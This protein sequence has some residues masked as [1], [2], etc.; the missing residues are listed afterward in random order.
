MR[1]AIDELLD[2]SLRDVVDI[3][4]IV[5]GGHLRV[6]HDLQQHIAEFVAHRVVIVG[7][8]RLE[9]LV[10][11]LEQVPGQALMGLFGVPGTSAGPAQPRHDPHEVEQ[12]FPLL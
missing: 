10:G 5:V 7:I 6:E 8:D 12:P 11:L 1:V 2:E 3:P 4:P 9:Q